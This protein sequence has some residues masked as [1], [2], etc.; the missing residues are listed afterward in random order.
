MEAGGFFSLVGA[1]GRTKCDVIAPLSRIAPV[2]NLFET[3]RP[4]VA[5][6]SGTQ[7]PN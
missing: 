6:T 1:E 2:A 3:R 5:N 7:S 4:Y